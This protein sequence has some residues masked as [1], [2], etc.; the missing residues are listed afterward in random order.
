MGTYPP[1]F[2]VIFT[3]TP[4]AGQS[5]AR[6]EFRGAVNDL[7]FDVPL[8][9]PPPPQATPTSPAVNSIGNNYVYLFIHVHVIIQQ[10]LSST[11]YGS[12]TSSID[13]GTKLGK[14]I[15]WST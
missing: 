12:I 6:I 10:L 2:H 13:Q 15:D 1:R 4:T 8:N 11:G 14:A 9:P 7:V 3:C 5:Q